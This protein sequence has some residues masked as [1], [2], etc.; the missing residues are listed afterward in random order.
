MQFFNFFE[1]FEFLNFLFFLNFFELFFS[2]SK[3]LTQLHTKSLI[4]HLII[5]Q[6]TYAGQSSRSVTHPQIAPAQARLTFE[7]LHC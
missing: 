3:F 4:T 2:I 5:G 1:F 6:S 7:F